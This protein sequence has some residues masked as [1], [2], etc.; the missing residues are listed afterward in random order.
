MPAH[1]ASAVPTPPQRA[2]W[3]VV[4]QTHALPLQQQRTLRARHSQPAIVERGARP[5][6]PF[7]TWRLILSGL[8]VIGI[9]VGACQHDTK[10]ETVPPRLLGESTAPG[11]SDPTVPAP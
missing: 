4:A 11:P 1:A 8:M 10:E 3:R 2:D 9:V 6:K 7:S 5:M